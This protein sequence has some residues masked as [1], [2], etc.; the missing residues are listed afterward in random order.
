MPRLSLL[1]ILIVVVALVL[2]TMAGI[3]VPA[4]QAQQVTPASWSSIAAP[5]S[6][7]VKHNFYNGVWTSGWAWAEDKRRDAFVHGYKIDLMRN[8]A[9]LRWED[10]GNG[11][12]GAKIDY[13]DA[14]CNDGIYLTGGIYW[15]DT[16]PLGSSTVTPTVTPRATNTPAPFVTPT[17][18]L[19]P[20]WTPAPIGTPIIIPFTPGPHA[21]NLSY[22]GMCV[23]GGELAYLYNIKRDGNGKMQA[24]DK[25]I[26][27]TPQEL[28]KLMNYEA[29]ATLDARVPITSM[30]ILLNTPTPTK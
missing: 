20:T 25:L 23:Y 30:I 1:Q 12:P 11:I 6:F 21:G 2:S 13:Y 15:F 22:N 14:T 18:T 4:L 9:C 28:R 17:E 5:F 29:A 26:C 7:G 8:G 27:T 24:F 3:S 10:M 16:K 19:R